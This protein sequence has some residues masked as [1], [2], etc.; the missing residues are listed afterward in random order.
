MATLLFITPN[1]AAENTRPILTISGHSGATSDADEITYDQASLEA[2]MT[3][4]ITT[5]TPWFDG[6]S[7][8]EGIPLEE[9]IGELNAGATKI[10]AIAL[11]DYMT[12]IPFDDIKAN[13]PILALK[14]DGEFMSVR[15]KGPLFI[16]YAYDSK[17]ELRTH[18]YYSRSA[19]QV[20]KLVIE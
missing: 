11:N 6:T 7:V 13:K 10:T 20:A 14:R 1:F 8:F 4:S 5:S 9:L 15:D 16:I 17:P 3:A 19:W 2:M 18:L 12:E